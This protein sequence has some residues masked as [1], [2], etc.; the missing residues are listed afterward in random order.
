MHALF[1]YFVLNIF[2]LSGVNFIG[3]KLRER[4]ELRFRLSY[5]QLPTS[6][7]SML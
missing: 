7:I 2:T 5:N 6:E 4:R 1:V 3:M